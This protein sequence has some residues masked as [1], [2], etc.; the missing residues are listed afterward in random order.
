M[1]S[2]R[3]NKEEQ[4]LS[5][6]NRP[7][8]SNQFYTSMPAAQK[9]KRVMSAMHRPKS[10]HRRRGPSSINMESVPEYPYFMP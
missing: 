5:A 1:Q 9:R 2:A 8:V 10:M 7:S 3:T 4:M 6:R